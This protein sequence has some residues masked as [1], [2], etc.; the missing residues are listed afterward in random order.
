MGFAKIMHNLFIYNAP[1][2]M[3]NGFELLENEDKSTLNDN[4]V[5]SYDEK[6]N[7]NSQPIP[8]ESA[9]LDISSVL[10]DNLAYLEKKFDVPKNQDIMIRHL[11]IGKQIPAAIIF[12]D[13]MIDKRTL[14]LSLLPSL[15]SPEIRDDLN[16]KNRMSQ[17]NI[18]DYLIEE[19]I[20]IHSVSKNTKYAFVIKQILN[21]VTALF[22][23][24]CAE[25]ILIESK[26][27]EKRAVESPKTET[28]IKGSQEGFT[29]SL[30]TNIALLR[31]IVKTENLITEK[32][33]LGDTSEVN[34]AL[35]YVKGI[36]NPAIIDEIKKRINS[37]KID[38][39]L[40]EG[41]LEQLIENNS[42][43][44]PPQI[45]STERSDRC[46]S[47]LMN[48]HAVIITEGTPTAIVI[49]ITFFQ[50]FHTSEDSNL[51]WPY[52]TFI[53]LIRIFGFFCS[54]LLPGLYCAIVLYHPEMIPTELLNS[55]AL[56]KETVPFPTVVEII[57]LDVSFELIREGAIRVPGVIGQTLGIVGA[58]IL[59]QAAVEAGLVSP[60]IVIIISITALGSFSVPNYQVGLTAR[61]TR[62]LFLFAGAAFGF[63][64]ISLLLFL[65]TIITSS[66]KSFGVPYLSP[67]SPKANS[68]GSILLKSPLRKYKNRPDQINPLKVKKQS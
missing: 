59:G 34:C 33:S 17:I 18:A 32:F 30:R 21:G 43:M 9:D 26:G 15:M 48:G 13:G 4:K 29:E 67:I 49:P 14:D 28:V 60:V 68:S 44:L 50:L 42:F 31:K 47:F 54:L 20:G 39:L 45:L 6:E 66:M 12:L 27:Y 64:G 36:V 1:Q 51:R 62:F 63:F 22:I 46:G 40:N 41:M 2:N 24:G 19:V 57:I 25:C 58:L 8:A 5:R 10:N 38:A 23:D 55:I 53:R 16:N 7:N 11:K 52:A 37:I 35:L 65:V 3:E 61:I 56:A